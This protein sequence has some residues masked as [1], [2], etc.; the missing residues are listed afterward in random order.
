MPV[1]DRSQKKTQYIT[2]YVSHN[3]PSIV[4]WEPKVSVL[5]WLESRRRRMKDTKSNA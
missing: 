1:H 4:Q 5:L 2:L 3:I